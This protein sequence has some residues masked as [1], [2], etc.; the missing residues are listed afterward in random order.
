MKFDPCLQTTGLILF[1]F[2]NLEDI[3]K[4]IVVCYYSKHTF[5]S[6]AFEHATAIRQS[7]KHQI[8][9]LIVVHKSY[10]IVS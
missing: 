10:V 1:Q 2:K 5:N 9:K 7:V 3:H 6:F 8:C 4:K